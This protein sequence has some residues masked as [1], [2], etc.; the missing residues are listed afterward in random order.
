M[1]TCRHRR[2]QEATCR[3]VCA[4]TRNGFDWSDCYS[5]VIRAA[6]KLRCKSAI[7]DGEVIVQDERGVSD[8]EAL[9]FAISWQPQG[10]IFYAFDLL[11]MNGKDTFCRSRT[12]YQRDV[13]RK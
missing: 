2:E 10:L 8:F 5:S 6:A 7:I 3:Q 9:K 4:Y 12:E 1:L 11:H 13:D